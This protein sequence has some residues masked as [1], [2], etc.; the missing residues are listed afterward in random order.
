[1]YQLTGNTIL[2]ADSKKEQTFKRICAYTFKGYQNK[3][4][5]IMQ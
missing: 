4:K 3:A 1:M 2:N 5:L